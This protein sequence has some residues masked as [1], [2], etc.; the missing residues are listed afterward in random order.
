MGGNTLG[1]IFKITSFGESH[2]DVIGIIID[3]IPAGLEIK[4][5]LIQKELNKR[6]PGQSKISTSRN[7]PDIVK[8]LSG[9]FKNKTTGAP[10]C[11]IIKNKDTKSSKYEKYKN[12]LRPSHVDY[13]ALKRYGGNSDYRGSGRFSGRIT[14]G[15][16]MAGAIAK[17]ILKEFK[18]DIFAY[19]KSI[20]DIV[21]NQNYNLDTLY[22]IEKQR[23]MSIVRCLD[24]NKSKNMIEVIENAKKE[25]DSVGGIIKCIV[26]NVPP[27]LGSPIFEGLES[28]LSK[29]IFSIGSIKGIEFGAG[30]NSTKMKGSQH[31]DPWIIKKG[32]IETVKNDSGGIIGGISIGMPIEFQ[33]AVKPTASIGQEQKTVD[34]NKLEESVLTLTGRHD[35]CIVPRAVIVVEA[36]TAIVILD[37]L[38]YEGKIPLIINSKEKN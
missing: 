22:E 27:G 25:N 35:P 6:K 17:L 12:L 21:D 38:L 3:G 19:T 23:E 36:M 20:G 7:E 31:N 24:A 9:V 5:E 16:V 37:Q 30:F 33:I 14:A 26:K 10:I 8:I 15:I 13:S 34:I 29:A 4:L 1:K 18:I 2:G 11:L 28:N 32:K